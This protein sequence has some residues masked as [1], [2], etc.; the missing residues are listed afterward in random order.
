QLLLSLLYH[1]HLQDQLFR[2]QHLLDQLLIEQRLLLFQ[3]FVL[4]FYFV[5]LRIHELQLLVVLV[6]SSLQFV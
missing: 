1:V 4:Q 5:V 2:F 6:F 3:L